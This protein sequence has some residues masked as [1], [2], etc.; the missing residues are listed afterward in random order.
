MSS[1]GQ[2]IRYVPA[3]MASAMVIGGAAEPGRSIGR[4]RSVILL[5]TAEFSAHR[6]GSP[7]EPPLG[8]R[9]Y[10]WQRLDES[11]SRIVE[12]HPRCLYE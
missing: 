3:A 6:V 1:L 5:R 12:H 8:V 2:H 9:F 7:S 4:I 10:R 11:A